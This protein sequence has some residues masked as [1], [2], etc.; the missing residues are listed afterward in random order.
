MAEHSRAP[1][2]S[3]A[4]HLSSLVTTLDIFA[5]EEQAMRDPSDLH[6]GMLW[7]LLLPYP[8]LSGST[9]NVSIVTLSPPY[10]RSKA[11]LTFV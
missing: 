3:P 8:R 6:E 1:Q 5:D 9:S 4:A 11:I 10:P 2:D 7:Q